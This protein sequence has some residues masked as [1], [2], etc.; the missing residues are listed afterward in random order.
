MIITF[1]NGQEVDVVFDESAHSYH[2][3]HKLADGS[4]TD[5]KPTHGIAAP[6]AV[7]Q[8]LS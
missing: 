6:L 7:V 3:A 2:I 8:S 5:Y 1:P 4:F